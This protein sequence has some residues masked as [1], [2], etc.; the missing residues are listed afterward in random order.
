[1]LQGIKT[2]KLVE[3]LMKEYESMTVD[4]VS[5]AQARETV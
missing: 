3:K 2:G 5:L 4:V 1:L